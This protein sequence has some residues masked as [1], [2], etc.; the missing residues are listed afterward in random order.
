VHRTPR[1][2][3]RQQ[4]LIVGSGVGG[5][6]AAFRLAT[7]GVANVVLE[8]GRRWP[9]TANGGTFPRHLERELFWGRSGPQ[10]LRPCRGLTATGMRLTLATPA[11]LA[12]R[13]TGLLDILVHPHLTVAC[14]AGVGGTTLV[15]GGV[16]GQ[17]H[18]EAFAR[19]FPTELDYEELDEIYYPRARERMGAAPFPASF[20]EHP[21]YRD[22]RIWRTAL[23]QSGLALEPISG[24][25]DLD[26]VQAE[27]NGT[28]RAAV[29]VGKYSYAGCDNGAK[30]S[31]DR[32]Y[33][34]RA[35]ATGRTVVRPLHHVTGISQDRGHY[36]VAVDRLD[37]RGA[38][39]ERLSIV[40]DRLIL[41]AGGVHTPKLLVE[42]RETGA[43]PRLNEHVGEQWG[44]NGDQAVLIATSPVPVGR[45]QAGPPS[46]FGWNH[47]GTA[48]VLP[49]P[50]NLPS[51]LLLVLG[52]GIPDAF[53]RWRYHSRSGAAGLEW[54]KGNDATAE[55]EFRETARR[56][57]AQ[58]PTRT[59]LID[60]IGPHTAHPLGGAVLGKATDA[61]GR[62]HG[63][64]GLY[65]LDGALMP[66]STA[67]VN[68][69]LTIAAVV[70]RCLD[71]I[72]DDFV[73]QG[74]PTPN[75]D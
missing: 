32:T 6:I 13:S 53:G 24:S 17:P 26:M 70:E 40:C 63:H 16:L 52:M 31:V 74:R 47:D 42:A 56:L 50:I 58:I 18:A 64:P 75:E 48:S 68:P 28:Q 45:G 43:L 1:R 51:G 33:L 39:V 72:I 67:A 25:F 71:H 19:V 69:A 61:Y 59:R 12:P 38:V 7:A 65:C 36:Q 22:A 20:L 49:G 14:G 34:A 9:I 60:P 35:E 54:D 23:E 15:Y 4:V 66:G 46:Y 3:E 30:L 44:T 8:R 21:R 27:L 11:L 2:R 41:A 55:R 29:T 5:S 73:E 37:E 62:L 10:S 57:A